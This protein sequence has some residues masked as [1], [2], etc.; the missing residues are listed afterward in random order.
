M[1]GHSPRTAA[2]LAHL[3]GYI[4]AHAPRLAAHPAGDV[5]HFDFAG[6]NLLVAGGRITGVVDWGPLPGDRAFDLASLLFYD[7]YYA[8]VAAT[9]ARIWERAL[10]LVTATTFGIYLAHLVHRQTDWSLRHHDA[11][12]VERVLGIGTAVL[13]DLV[14]HRGQR[15]S[16][17]RRPAGAGGAT[18]DTPRPER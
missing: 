5:V 17:E 1:R 15:S 16:T 14:H 18:S 12:M 7:G 4:A 11:A 3:Q 6:P 2:L 9:R 8:D 10:T 13:H